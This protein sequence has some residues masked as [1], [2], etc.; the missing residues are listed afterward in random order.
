MPHVGPDPI[1]ELALQ[2]GIT[3][4]WKSRHRSCEPEVS[5]IQ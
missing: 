3:F 5:H 2:N 1:H 4:C